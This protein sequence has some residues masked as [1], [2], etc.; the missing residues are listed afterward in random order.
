MPFCLVF[1]E[2]NKLVASLLFAAFLFSGCAISNQNPT[3]VQAEITVI[4]SNSL[5]VVP[6]DNRLAIVND[7]RT[8]AANVQSMQV[9]VVPPDLVDALLAFA[10][11]ADRPYL[12]ALIA[13]AVAL[14]TL[15]GG[16]LIVGQ[17]VSSNPQLVAYLN[18]LSNGITNGIPQAAYKVHL[19][20][21][22]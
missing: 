22:A 21:K 18:A 6:A 19:K 12:Q 20:L 9:G 13:N 10:P 5:L 15:T 8:I 11:S 7:L 2:V 17:A 14:Y 3:T 1:N 4:I 16:Q